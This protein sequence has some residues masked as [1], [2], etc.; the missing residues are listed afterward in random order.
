MQHETISHSGDS[1]VSAEAN[2]DSP[3]GGVKT[4]YLADETGATDAGLVPTFL[5]EIARTMQATADRERERIAADIADR[6]SAL[7]ETVRF[8][9]STEADELRRLADADIDQINE[10]SAGQVDR[11]RRETDMR[12]NSR[13]ED[14]EQHLRQQDAVVE[15]EIARATEAVE[16]YQ[17]E[18]GRFVGRLVSQQ[19]PTE[20][21]RLASQLPE[22]PPV[23][24]IASEA[25]AD[26]LAQL[27]S[28]QGAAVLAS[29][30]E[31]DAGLVGVMDPSGV[32][33]PAE[34]TAQTSEPGQTEAVASAAVASAAVASAAMASDESDV[35]VEP[36]AVTSTDDV[37]LRLHA[38][39]AVAVIIAIVLLLVI[40][41]Q[42][43]AA[44]SS[45]PAQGI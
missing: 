39:L 43:H 18:L 34:P 17:N 31:R 29:T 42:I 20:I 1:A 9:A 24:V 38:V 21:A 26:A 28:S 40:T 3:G 15:R 10:W 44:S 32:S 14:L 36:H 35:V 33:L 8:R 2:G 23:E 12:V 4:A 19:E 27:S 22:P 37:D 45:G 6:L 11:V 25:R 30:N 5:Q 7:V 16:A 13:R 41:G